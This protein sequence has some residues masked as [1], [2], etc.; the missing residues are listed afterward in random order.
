ME[1]GC[2]LYDETLA[3]MQVHFTE[4]GFMP[5]ALVQLDAALN[6]P[7]RYKGQPYPFDSPDSIETTNRSSESGGSGG[8]GGWIGMNVPVPH[9]LFRGPDDT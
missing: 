2:Q 4:S 3:A 5:D 1:L 9:G 6:G 7:A 8:S